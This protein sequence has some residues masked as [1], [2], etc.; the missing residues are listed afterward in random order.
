[1][2]DTRAC[3]PAPLDAWLT[4][5][6]PALAALAFIGVAASG[7]NP[8][9][10]AWLNAL[11]PRTSDLLWANITILG[12][13][14]V[15]LTLCLPLWRRKPDL[16]WAL[17]IGAL[18]ATSWV[19]VL[20]PL[21]DAPRPPAVLGD[22]VHVIGPAYRAGS[23]P[24]GHATTIFAVAGLYSLGLRS[25]A[26]TALALAVAILAAASRSVVGVHWPLD[27]LAGMFGGWLSAALGLA[28]A[29]RLDFGLRPA[30]QW[31]IALLL[32]GCAI[33]LLAGHRTGYPQALWLQ[34]VLALVCLAAAA[35]VLVRDWRASTGARSVRS[36]PLRQ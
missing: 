21:V 15:A 25:P 2:S 11:G 6:P 4:W 28:L 30:V 26:V 24:S 13:T 19:H 17:A 34:R 8:E 22:A 35:W 33:A 29:R 20:K 18:L 36:D 3:G 1:M 16:V 14:L 31:V 5:L 7:I 23:F 12:D 27:V 32:G 9:V 10:F